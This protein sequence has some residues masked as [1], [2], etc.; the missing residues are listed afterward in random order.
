[1]DRSMRAMVLLAIAFAL[2]IFGLQARAF[3]TEDTE[4]K[5][6]AGLDL[7]RLKEIPVISAARHEQDQAK[8]P[9]SISIITANEIRLR[10]FRN[11]PEA[12][13]G[14]TG[15]FLQQ[16]NYA[17]G[18]PIIR[19]MVGNRVL[20]MI[21]GI[22]LNNGTYRLG[23]NQYLNTIDIN[24]VE[25]IEVLRGAGSVL[26]GSDAFG[27]VINVITKPAPDALMGREFS[28]DA[29]L[30]V[31][32][33]DGSGSGH[34]GV[35]GAVSRL[36]WTGGYSQEGWGDLRG[37]RGEKQLYTGYSQQGADLQLRYALGSNQSLVLGAMRLRQADALR[38]DI[39]NAG[40]DLEYRWNPQGRDIM[41][42]QYS[43]SSLGKL[44]DALQI[45]AA[46]QR[47]IEILYRIAATTPSVERRYVDATQGGNLTIQLSS[48]WRESHILTY[49]FEANSDWI[50]S[51][52]T[53]L[54]LNA[55]SMA[56]GKGNY[57]DGSRFSSASLFFQDEWD[58]TRRLR[59][60]V[61]LRHD[62]FRI[63]GH[64]S[65]PM[66]GVTDVDSS[67]SALTGSAYLLYDL[68][69]TVS[70]V[71]GIAQG[72]RAPNLDDSTIL[73]GAG[74]RFEIPNSSL[75]PERSTNFEA[76][77]RFKTGRSN[78]SVAYFEDHYRDLIDRAPALLNGKSFVDS[79]GNGI[80]DGKE[81]DVYQRR[82][83]GRASARGLE[84]ESI[85]C[86]NDHWTWSFTATW[87][88][89]TDL[90]IS[91]PLSRIPPLNGVSRITWRPNRTFWIE[92]AGMGGGSQRRLSPG[93]ITDVRI[94]P[95]GTAGFAT[96]TLRA[97]L[98]RTALAGLSVAWENITDSRYRLHGSG[99]DRPGSSL[100]M[101]YERAF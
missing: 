64:V 63:L 70:V 26:Y 82:N 65:D 20:I 25:R 38:T 58:W 11:V 91:K 19:G 87:T 10:N 9:R 93:D 22:R 75:E 30:R 18:S 79:N 51:L 69:P 94:G 50:T 52:R 86:L 17:G 28:G 92:V 15:V 5:H 68:T 96:G 60:V 33:A 12:V 49:G 47:P 101:G 80:K 100:V 66:T 84:T 53:D 1:M 59:T 3:A 78:I 45:T 23:P 42:V 88:Y 35:S 7:I 97:G 31:G 6:L 32:S 85:V 46:Y 54:D 89:G 77:L 56:R 67:P 13:A 57:P 73:G 40:T 21:N 36:S 4:V 44:V 99:I 16:T 62:R 55:G 83:I 61:G 37:G 74:N 41:Y 72:F 43:N 14:L 71:G 76:G 81:L 34:V 48:R 95:A 2:E 98:R 8:S 24:M 39:L 29:H 27:G 90:T